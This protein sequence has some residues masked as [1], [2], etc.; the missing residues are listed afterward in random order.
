MLLFSSHFS[1]YARG[2][3]LPDTEVKWRVINSKSPTA[4]VSYL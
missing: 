3:E 4:Q 1:K 2:R